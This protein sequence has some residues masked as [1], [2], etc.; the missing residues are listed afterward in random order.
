MEF[1]V[2][3]LGSFMKDLVVA[4]PRRPRI[5]ETLRGNSFREYL[6]GKGINQA[7]AAARC[8]A[9]TAMLG[10]VGTDRYGDEFLEMLVAEGIDATHVQ[11]DTV[12]GTGVG[13]PVV[14]PSGAN[15]IIIVPRA[16]DAVA[17]EDI[18]AAAPVIRSSK[19]LLV[20]L[21]LPVPSAVS[22]LEIAREAGVL[23]VLNPAPFTLLPP[24]IAELI[25]IVVPNEVEAEQL[26]RIEATDDQVLE[27]ARQLRYGLARRGAVVTLGERGAVVVD[28]AGTVKWLPAND[29]QPVDTVGA[30]DAFCGALAARLA[31]G[32]SLL[33]AAQFAGAA[34]G[35]ATTR[36]GGAP[37]MPYRPEIEALLA[38]H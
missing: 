6:G 10:R 7:V 24:E 1:D 12:R 21:E 35:L 34:G 20:Q 8:G 13:L 16:N 9:R 30:G 33:D 3:V 32:D 17:P 23:T 25:D 4:A 5:G 36:S 15:S 37:A 2:C 38:Q 14:E 11:R 29:V 19:V 31:E 28:E 22:A 26:T 18:Q 27:V